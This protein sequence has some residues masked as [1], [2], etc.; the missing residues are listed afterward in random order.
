MKSLIANRP[1]VSP[2]RTLL[3]YLSLAFLFTVIL[4]GCGFTRFSREDQKKYEALSVKK[5]SERALYFMNRNEHK[6]AVEL[7]RMILAS[8]GVSPKNA[9]WAQYEIGFCYRVMG[10]YRLAM[11]NYQKVITDYPQEEAKSARL[12]AQT[13][14]QKPKDKKYHG[15]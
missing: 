1:A 14:I 10:K 13:Q 6:K 5:K 15:F 11:E 12:L 8:K 2:A 9:S 3:P 4:A 7:Y